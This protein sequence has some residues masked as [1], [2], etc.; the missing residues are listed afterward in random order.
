ML[1]LLHVQGRTSHATCL[2]PRNHR[3]QVGLGTPFIWLHAAG[4]ASEHSFPSSRRRGRSVVRQGGEVLGMAVSRVEWGLG[5]L[6]EPAT[7][8]PA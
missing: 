1:L 4:A 6:S 5:M 7:G 2:A 8:S 3:T